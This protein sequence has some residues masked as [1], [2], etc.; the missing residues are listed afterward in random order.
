M[1]TSISTTV[2]RIASDS[3]VGA[4]MGVLD[5]A[6]KL[7]GIV[8]PPIGGALYASWAFGP[9]VILLSIYT[10]LMTVAYF[11]FRGYVVPAIIRKEDETAETK[12]KK[13]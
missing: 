13:E 8:G 6:E 7:A 10:G 2:T 4:L 1:N 3:N 5:T 9:V 11:G 12:P